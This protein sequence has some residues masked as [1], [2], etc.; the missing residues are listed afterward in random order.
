[1]AGIGGK[2]SCSFISKP[3]LRSL[4]SKPLLVVV[5]SLVQNLRG[6]PEAFNLKKEENMV[7]VLKFRTFFFL[8]SNKM[9]VIM[10][11]IHNMHAIIANREDP[12]Q[13][14]SETGSALLV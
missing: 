7:N 9:L 1:M 5:V 4:S 13:S 8:F 3:I 2:T 12:D 10:A 6:I 14:A 11:E